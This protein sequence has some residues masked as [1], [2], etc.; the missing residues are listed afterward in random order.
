MTDQARATD[1][2]QGDAATVAV[3]LTDVHK[4][5]GEVL[6]LDGADLAVA[7]G[8]VHGLLGGNGAGK[9][10]LMNVLYGLYRPDRG[11]IRLADHGVVD[12]DSPRDAIGYGIGMVHQR[13]LQVD[14]YTVTENIVLGTDLASL[15]TLDV[16]SAES[17]IRELSERFG[18]AVDPGAVVEDLPVGARQRVEILKALYRNAEVLILDEPTTNLTPQEVEDL[19]SS[20]EAMVGEGMAVVFITHK[21]R[22]ALTICDRLTVMRAGRRVTTL[23]AATATPDELARAMIGGEAEVSSS[24]LG[25]Q[26]E[27]VGEAD[28]KERTALELAD[29][30]VHNDL[31]AVAVDGCSVRLRHSEVLGV[32]GVAGNGQ[33]ELAEAIAGARPAESGQIVL[34]GDDVT[35]LGADGRLRAGV[36]YV[37]ENRHRD[38]ILPSAT[39]SENMILGAHRS[40][41]HRGRWLLAWKRIRAW[42]RDR[43]AEYDIQATGPGALAGDLSGGNIQRVILARAFARDPK[44]LVAHNPTRGLD[45]ASADFV[46][47]QLEQMTDQGHAVLLL[48]ED[49]DELME[50]SDRIV[51][52]FDGAIVGE[53]GRADFDRYELGRLMGGVEAGT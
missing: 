43:M 3:E 2:D 14:P 41:D 52:M 17:D 4:S 40:S 23:G 32:A 5:F 35:D 34:D 13:F 19:F 36:V 16:R 27:I 44:I 8:E 11:S 37:P 46:H 22:E 9:T 15:P 20:L 18:L 21:I 1:S 45:I 38:G 25:M 6:A 26:D 53:L 51:V 47:G 12:I 39:V 7:G 50:L 10:T 49:L 33:G 31:D 24:V 30:V 28:T 48:S 29:V 42:T